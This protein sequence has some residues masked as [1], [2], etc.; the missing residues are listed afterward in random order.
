MS[1]EILGREQNVVGGL[2]GPQAI[3]PALGAGGTNET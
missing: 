1:G 2:S 3:G